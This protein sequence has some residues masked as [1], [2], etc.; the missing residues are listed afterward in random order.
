MPNS[1]RQRLYPLGSGR[2]ASTS[3]GHLGR[4]SR[5]VPGRLHPS[6]TWYVRCESRCLRGRRVDRGSRARVAPTDGGSSVRVLGC[7]SLAVVSL[8]LGKTPIRSGKPCSGVVVTFVAAIVLIPSH[9]AD[10]T[11]IATTL[12]Y[13]LSMVLAYVFSVRTAPVRVGDFIPA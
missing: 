4:A 5:G 7:T 1:W 6:V 3:S 11:A 12:G 9:G 8:R 10:G 2:R 13:V